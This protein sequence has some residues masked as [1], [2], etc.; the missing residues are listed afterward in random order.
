MA[1]V[2]LHSLLFGLLSSLSRCS[3]DD[4]LGNDL[5]DMYSLLG[6]ALDNDPESSSPLLDEQ[7]DLFPDFAGSVF[8]QSSNLHHYFFSCIPGSVFQ[9][10]LGSPISAR[11]TDD[12]IVISQV[13]LHEEL[14]NLEN[15]VAFIPRELDNHFWTILES[16]GV[17]RQFTNCTCE[18][19]SAIPQIIF[20]F[21]NGTIVFDSYD[22]FSLDE[23]RD[24]C[25]PKFAVNNDTNDLILLTDSLPGINVLINQ[26]SAYFC[27]SRF[28]NYLYV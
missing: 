23:T 1:F 13:T 5:L 4:L 2:I 12:R 28:E 3:V 6:V 19:I 10:A 8:D 25:F 16:W 11:T 20:L 21:T 27:D 14:F 18:A 22:F 26:Q 7:Y 9:H 17:T 24:I 15:D